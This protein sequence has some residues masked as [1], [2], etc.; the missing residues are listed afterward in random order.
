MTGT[1]NHLPVD[2]VTIALLLACVVIGVGYLKRTRRLT[3]EE[4]IRSYVFPPSIFAA[5]IRYHPHISENDQLRVAQALRDFFVVR[6]RARGGLI[7]MPSRVVDDLW[8]QF[9]LDTREYERFCK[10]AFGGFFHHL[11]AAANPPGKRMDAALRTTWRYA[12]LTEG[13]YSPSPTRLPLLFAID[14]ELQ[15]ENGH[16]FINW[17]FSAR[18]GKNAGDNGGGAACGGGD[19]H[20]GG[21]GGHG[22]C[23][24]GCGGH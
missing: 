3:R 19:S 4:F 6:L 18:R 17:L 21:C 22:G 9:I 7:G 5:L 12:C 24:G 20:G 16:S 2:I 10:L 23:G 8:H 15:I 14:S 11:P 13:I 1:N